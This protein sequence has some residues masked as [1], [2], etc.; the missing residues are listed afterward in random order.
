MVKK[1]VDIVLPI[2]YGNYDEIENSLKKVH[3]FLSRNFNEYS[4]KIIIGLNGPN[5]K[6]IFK[7]CKSLTEKYDNTFL[8]YTKLPGRGASLSEI[9]FNSLSDY[10]SFMDIDL[11]TDLKHFPLMIKELDNGCDVCVGSRYLISSDIKRYFFRYFLSR[12]YNGFFTRILLNAKFT[13]AQCGFKSA[14]MNVAHNVIPL[15]KDNNWFWDTEFLYLSQ[16]KGYKLMEIPVIWKEQPNSG[17][18]FFKTIVDFILKSLE[19]RLRKV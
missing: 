19:L 8:K 4:W 9:W 5:K 15:I 11:S 1:S 12:V 3:D 17:V 6:G 13:D 14:K 16:K 18:K 7:L 2:Y 10:V